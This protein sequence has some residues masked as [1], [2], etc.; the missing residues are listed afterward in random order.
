MDLLLVAAFLAGLAAVTK[1]FG[2]ALLPLMFL[3]VLLKGQWRSTVLLAIPLAM[4]GGFEAWTTHLYGHGLIQSAVDAAGT[5]RQSHF[6]AYSAEFLTG[7]TFLGGCMASVSLIPSCL[8]PVRFFMASLV[9]IPMLSMLGFIAA[10]RLPELEP[11]TE[12][13]DLLMTYSLFVAA[14]LWCVWLCLRDLYVHR[15]R[16]SLWL[17]TWLA[18]TWT[19]AV[20]FNWTISARSLLPMAPAMGIVVAR[21]VE[22]IEV[23][24]PRRKGVAIFTGLA[25]SAAL[26]LWVATA[27]FVLAESG[28]GAA[29]ELLAECDPTRG[30]IWFTGDWGFQ[31]Y[32][33]AG[34]AVPLDLASWKMAKGSYFVAALSATQVLELPPTVARPRLMRDFPAGL[35]LATISDYRSAGFY[36]TVSGRLPFG[37]GPVPPRRFV[38]HDILFNIGTK[39][40]Q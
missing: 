17:I 30:T 13:P 31:Y 34:G 39:S 6:R 12:R 11:I 26:S 23:V 3:H 35:G 2:L 8:K 24:A 25:L 21:Y 18:G 4:I 38:L 37:I 28:R 36:S 14:G 33:Q 27:D 5:R 29:K 20:A 16:R 1:Y 9:A 40:S 15:D 19:F 22:S 32:M 7:L 10:T